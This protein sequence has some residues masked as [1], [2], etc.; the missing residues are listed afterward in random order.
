M[1]LRVDRRLEM[2]TKIFKHFTTVEF[3]VGAAE[4][5]GDKVKEFGGTKAL[6]VTD[7]GLISTGMID[8]IEKYLQDAQIPVVRFADIKGNPVVG[9]IEQ[10]VKVMKDNGC[11]ITI[12]IGGGSSMDVAKAINIVEANGGNILDY[13]VTREGQKNPLK[14]RKKPLIA[15]P[16]TSGTGSE[17]TIWSVLT[18][19]ARNMKASFGHPWYA[20]DLAL[21]DPV[22]TASVPAGLTAATGMDALTHAIEAYTSIAPMPQT[23][24]LA[25]HAI[26]LI[27]QNL[28]QAVANGKNISAR[29]G[30]LMG[31]LMAGMAFNSSPVGCVHAMAHTLGG[32]YDTPH[33]VAN[34]IMLPYVMEYNITACPERFADV[35]VA[36][37]EVGDGLS[38]IEVADKSIAAVKRMS[39]DVGIPRL[40][41]VGC[42][43]EDIPKL[44]ELAFND[45]NHNGNPKPMTVDKMIEIYN[46]AY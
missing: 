10:G 24:A 8:T 4:T 7:P 17:V 33:G 5:I 44:A 13:E 2:D 35:A 26:E 45:M 32:A 30:M 39:S 43:K 14:K 1:Q 34:A 40:R 41:E 18:D 23:D 22:L 46:E 36:M 16:T 27:S 15:I 37:G 11:D 3:G 31:S 29:E 28:R 12:A 21:A 38:V 19:P 25:L 20:P 9:C 6:L 42:K